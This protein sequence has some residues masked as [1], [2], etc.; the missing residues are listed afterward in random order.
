MAQPNTDTAQAAR[1]WIDT[2]GARG[3]WRVE[4]VSQRLRKAP[5]GT[6]K[7]IPVRLRRFAEG[8]PPAQ[9]RAAMDY[10]LSLAPYTGV[11]LNGEAL[12]GTYRPTLTEWRRD[13]RDAVHRAGTD[14]SDS[15]YTLV[16]D[17]VDAAD[18]DALPATVSSSCSQ[19]E[20]SR[21]TWDAGSVDDLPEPEQGVTWSIQGLRRNEDG[22][23]D[24]ALVKR[25]ART[26]HM[27]PLV[28]RV[29]PS[30]TTTVETW[31][32][33]YG[34]E[35]AYTDHTGAPLRIP[36]AS[37]SQG[38]RVEIQAE[39]NQDC[40]FKIR[41]VTVAATPVDVSAAGSRACAEEIDYEYRWGQLSV[42]QLS[43]GYGQGVSRSVQ[44][45]R[46]NDDGTFDY[47]VA[48]RR[49][50]TQHMPETAV[51]SSLPDTVT[52]ETWNNLYGSPDVGFHDHDGNA[53]SVPGASTTVKVDVREQE[54]CT[55]QVKATRTYP[56]T[57]GASSSSTHTQFEGRHTASERGAASP[58][59]VA[60]GASGGKIV[61]HSSER[62]K[63]GR[64][65]NEREVTVE[66]PVSDAEV[67]VSV[68]RRGKRTEKVS[69]N[70]ASA[71][72]TSSIGVGGSVKV[73]K[74]PGG[75][76]NNTIRTWSQ[77][78]RTA[79]ATTCHETA[80]KHT[81]SKTQS[82]VS[83]VPDPGHL[84]RS[85]GTTVRR[86]TEMD[87]EGA[88]TQTDETVTEHYVPRHVES[89]T[90]GLTGVTH[91][92]RAASAPSALAP[93]SYSRAG[94]GKMVQNTVT[95]AGRY[96][97]VSTEVVRS[98]SPLVTGELRRATIYERRDDETRSDPGGALGGKSW[99]V[100]GSGHVKEVTSTLRDDG[101]SVV[102]RS[103]LTERPVVGAEVSVK[104]AAKMVL[105]T[106]KDRNV[107]PVS[108]A[109]PPSTVGSSV[110]VVRTPGGLADVVT[111]TATPTPTPDRAGS[112]ATVFEKSTL[113]RTVSTGLPSGSD[114]A[115]G[116]GRHQEI[117]CSMD[118]YGIGAR[119]VKTVQET[120][121]ADA[122]RTVER[123]LHVQR[124][125]RRG[126]NLSSNGDVTLD[127]PGQRWSY[128]M[129]PGGYF[130]VETSTEVSLVDSSADRHEETEDKYKRRVL[131]Q[132]IKDSRY[133]LGTKRASQPSQG[134][135]TSYEE[136]RHADGYAVVNT[137]EETELPVNRAEEMSTA[138]HFVK[139]YK[140]VDRS[141]S[142]TKY[143]E[144]DY[145]SEGKP[146]YVRTQTV[147]P[148]DRYDY[149]EEKV[150]AAYREWD[151]PE[152]N[153]TRIYKKGVNFR[154]AK[155][156]QMDSKCK[157]LI[158]EFEQKLKNWFAKDRGLRA[159]TSYDV[160]P[161]V[162]LNDFGLYD[163]HVSVVARWQNESA[164]QDGQLEYQYLNLWFKT[165]NIKE[166]VS[167]A[168]G[169]DKVVVQRMAMKR[170]HRYYVARG[171]DNLF[172]A[173][174]NKEY[175]EGTQVSFVPATASF[176]MH[177]ITEIEKTDV[178]TTVK[179][180]KK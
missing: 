134:K 4:T 124:T 138:T 145:V 92:I 53:V 51:E 12:P 174:D 78:A 8:C 89:W 80:F 20:T 100:A 179:N 83:S 52:E 163:G 86:V 164:G 65:V 3:Q 96:D 7:R 173:M 17:L 69:R 46:R 45:I 24:Y 79:V 148:G 125:T 170:K 10:L 161:Q 154:N 122:G 158:R 39:E 29:T 77:A 36:G 129:T 127:S 19:V 50:L 60:P 57:Y 37:Q 44:D 94:I 180:A 11:V 55:Y 175:F 176:T 2:L 178:E 61:K 68:G 81:H 114:A 113:V 102:T 126:R 110:E 140:K 66:R 21:W 119:D 142:S 31:D 143:Q 117:S 137:V 25:T 18:D 104:R 93:L 123:G 64:Y 87:D 54:D 150:T 63:D 172:N 106:Q 128:N 82:G 107:Q 1:R 151:D 157:T 67:T 141:V 153:L 131:T 95:D 16:Q 15:T 147:T 84:S 75:R 152:V 42:E 130:D 30:E 88:I 72:S 40:T 62:Q 111:V 121:V 49:A 118:D 177:A 28:T 167:K 105:R 26:Q 90:V 109:S 48:T 160:T 115:A 34:T 5:D 156:S 97:T 98:G 146:Q 135:V 35:G 132:E 33:V 116:G 6:V 73:E 159:P 43:G 23:I 71:A 99:A 13:R 112:S 120:P 38:V 155:K 85:A 47:R 59:G 165:V 133:P 101:T 74:T 58:L 149:V 168:P 144:E 139:R 14:A 41:A 22:T 171:Y 162:T 108:T 27:G 103:D 76:Y 56:A 32:N 169:S 9:M 166:T 70:Q 91:T 136:V